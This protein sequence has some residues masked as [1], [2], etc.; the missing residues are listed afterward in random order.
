MN[1]SE[2]IRKLNNI[3]IDVLDDESIIITEKTT[4]KDVEDWDSLTHIQLVVAIEKFFKL[5]FTSV[6]IRE[7]KDVGEM[8]N[9]IETRLENA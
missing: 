9:T 4:A 8:C 2:I 5:H 1:R 3:F 6:E 7:W